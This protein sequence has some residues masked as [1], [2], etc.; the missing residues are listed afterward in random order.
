V[1]DDPTG[2]TISGE[3]YNG[4]TAS[5]TNTVV[6]TA[7]DVYT[8]EG[9]GAWSLAAS[10]GSSP[11]ASYAV[12]ASEGISVAFYL[13]WTSSGG[14]GTTGSVSSSTVLRAPVA[15]S[16]VVVSGSE[17]Q[18]NWTCDAGTETAFDVYYDTVGGSS[19]SLGRTEGADATDGT[20]TG[21][22]AGNNYK[23]KVIARNT[24]VS[25]ADSNEVT[26]YLGAIY[27]D[28]LT[29]TVT[30]T[31]SATTGQTFVESLSDS[32]TI[33]DSETESSTMSESLSDTVTITDLCLGGQTIKS[34]YDYYIGTSDGYVH[35]TAQDLLS[36]N[37]TSITSS[38]LSKT[39]DFAEI[40]AENTGRWKTIYRIEFI[41][42]ELDTAVTTIIKISTDG[43]NTWATQS[44]SLGTSGDG[45]IEHSHYHWNKTGQFFEVKVEWASSDKEF[46]FLGF[47]VV[48]DDA[49]DQYEVV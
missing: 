7:L 46:Q 23:F 22:S 45:R 28:T 37:G 33:T 44:K 38:W 48:F 8:K 24:Y 29:D 42:K 10:L 43:G 47:D 4:Y 15:T 13:D 11:P 6:Y 35:R 18:V 16:A 12:T 21:L 1:S 49:G 27:A 26:A 5:W 40:D 25:S 20:V 3:A 34:D 17:V 39:L 19:W 2:L 9:S 30:V 14:S 41:Y 31:D 36:D 32:V